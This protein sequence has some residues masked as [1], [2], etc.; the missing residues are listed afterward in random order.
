MSE[1]IQKTCPKCG[2]QLRIPKHI[3]GML[4]SCPSCDT[5]FASDFK[6]GNIKEAESRGVA[7][8][9]FELPST[10]LERIIR[11]FVPR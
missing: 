7:T 6:I 2:Q 10:F 11:F 3:G 1:Y 4:M 8:T 5:K 9:I